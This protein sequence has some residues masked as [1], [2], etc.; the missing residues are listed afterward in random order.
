VSFDLF[1]NGGLMRGLREHLN[2]AGAEFLE[3]THTAP[4]YRLHSIDD[5]HPGMYEVEEGGVSVAGELYRV[6]PEV[7]ARVAAGGPRTCTSERSH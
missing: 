2:L 4:C 5:R 6:S 3:V 1:V 7:W